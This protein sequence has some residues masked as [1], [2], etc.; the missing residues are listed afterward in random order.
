MRRWTKPIATLAVAALV[1]GLL[2]IVLRPN[3]VRVAV[4]PVERGRLQVTVDE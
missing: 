4:A 1:I 3:P 2:I